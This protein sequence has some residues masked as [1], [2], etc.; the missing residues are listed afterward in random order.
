[1]AWQTKRTRTVYENPW[2]RVREDDVARPDGGEGIYGVVELRHPAVFVVA[3]DEEGRVLLVEVDRY[4]VGRSW[5]VVAGGSDGEPAEQA[6]R[7]ELLEESGL[8]AAEWIEVGRMNALNGICVAPETVF[9][10]RGLMSAHDAGAHQAEEGITASR[11]VPLD[12]ALRMSV[13]GE[14][15]DGESIAALAMAAVHLKRL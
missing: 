8:E 7:R 12:E 9:L 11:W 14:I 13:S 2:I 15:S 3:L 10:A 1:M 6:A 5:E 4:T